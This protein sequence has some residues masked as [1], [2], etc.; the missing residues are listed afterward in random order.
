MGTESFLH[1]EPHTWTWALGDGLEGGVGCFLPVKIGRAFWGDPAASLTLGEPMPYGLLQASH[2]REPEARPKRLLFERLSG[3]VGR[4]GVFARVDA[5]RASAAGFADDVTRFGLDWPVPRSTAEALAEQTPFPIFFTHRRV[6]LFRDEEHRLG[7]LAW[8][9][10]LL[11]ERGRPGATW[12]WPD[13]GL[14]AGARHG[15]GH[16]MQPVLWAIHCLDWL[17][18][19]VSGKEPWP[20]ARLFFKATRFVEQVLGATWI[21]RVTVGEPAQCVLEGAADARR[22]KP[23]VALM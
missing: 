20:Q 10:Q 3:V 1:A 12:L 8:T 11:G 14:A 4:R 13:W 9:E 6:P 21:T 7:A 23:P 2:F 22:A 17:W 19:N 18:G 15:H 16:F 5:R